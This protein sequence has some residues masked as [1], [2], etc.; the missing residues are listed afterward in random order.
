MKIVSLK[1]GQI[2]YFAPNDRRTIS[3]CDITGENLITNEEIRC[4]RLDQSRRPSL[5]IPITAASGE[6]L[7]EATIGLKG[8]NLGNM[9]S[10]ISQENEYLAVIW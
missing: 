5:T 1:E 6:L 9:V 8:P 10:Q 7:F 4:L 2:S 3:I